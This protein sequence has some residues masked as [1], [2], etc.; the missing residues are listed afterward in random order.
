MDI[1][2]YEIPELSIA[3]LSEYRARG[4]GT[5][6]LLHLFEHLKSRYPAIYLSVSLEN[7]ALRL[8]QRLGFEIIA[9]L[10]V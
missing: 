2:S 7:P 10:A 5:E 3:I 6:L 8:Y 1:L 9:Q 4:V